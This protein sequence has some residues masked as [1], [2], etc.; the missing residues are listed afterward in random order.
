M[1]GARTDTAASFPSVLT[2]HARASFVAQGHGI[3]AGYLRPPCLAAAA[4]ALRR[5]GAPGPRGAAQLA[6]LASHPRTP[7]AAA[8]AA[9]ACLRACADTPRGRMLALAPP[10][11]AG[12]AP[13]AALL[14]LVHT[15]ARLA[16]LTVQARSLRLICPLFAHLLTLFCCLF[17]AAA[18]LADALGAFGADGPSRAALAQ[19]TQHASASASASASAASAFAFASSAAAPLSALLSLYAAAES[20]PG[21][22]AVPLPG[23]AAPPPDLASATTVEEAEAAATAAAARVF[24]PPAV[25]AR[26]AAL[27]AFAVLAGDAH[28]LR[29]EAFQRGAGVRRG[30]CVSPSFL[31]CTFSEKIPPSHPLFSTAGRAGA[32]A[33]A[34]PPSGHS[35]RAGRAC[36]APHC[37]GPGMGRAPESVPAGAF[38]VRFR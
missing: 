5:G 7:R 18:A 29:A 3:V 16:T 25:A 9:L 36:A 31:R 4:A 13:L 12:A 6:A 11:G 22:M 19:Q 34:A 30:F 24:N 1:R 32:L 35:P 37:A 26:R 23:G 17:Q 10:P 28:L 27:A 20:L 21:G 15:P 8:A 2:P 14:A 33:A 38:C